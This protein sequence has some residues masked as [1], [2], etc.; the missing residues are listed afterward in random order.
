M[1]SRALSAFRAPQRLSGAATF[2]RSFFSAGGSGSRTKSLKLSPWLIGSFS[3]FV[4]ATGASYFTKKANENNCG[5]LQSV[6][7]SA[8]VSASLPHPSVYKAHFLS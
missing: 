2:T 4:A 7:A 8:F 6:Q 3:A 1:A 5:I